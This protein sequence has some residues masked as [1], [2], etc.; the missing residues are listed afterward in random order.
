MHD[1]CIV[2]YITIVWFL[3]YLGLIVDNGAKI[4]M[5]STIDVQRCMNAVDP[6]W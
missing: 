1:L 6:K 2:I 4:E 5:N 3:F